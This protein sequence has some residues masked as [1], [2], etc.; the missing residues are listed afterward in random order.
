MLYIYSFICKFIYLFELSVLFT[1]QLNRFLRKR[2]L[3][4]D[5]D[6]S[7]KVI[8]PQSMLVVNAVT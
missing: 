6:F 7:E 4:Y 1:K 2:F 5:S 3:R 8:A